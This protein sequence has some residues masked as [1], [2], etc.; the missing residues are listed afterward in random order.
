[1][2][3]WIGE[4]WSD[5]ER[6]HEELSPADFPN[7][8]CSPNS[9]QQA[10]VKVSLEQQFE[11]L[12]VLEKE[13]AACTG[14]GW[15]ALVVEAAG[16]W[17]ESAC[18]RELVDW[19]A[20]LHGLDPTSFASKKALV[21]DLLLRRLP[22]LPIPQMYF[23]SEAWSLFSKEEQD[24]VSEAE[25]NPPEPPPDEAKQDGEDPPDVEDAEAPLS[26]AELAMLES[27]SRRASGQEKRK[28]ADPTGGNPGVL[29]STR[30]SQFLDAQIRCM[31]QIAK[32]FEPPSKKIKRTPLES[33]MWQAS[34]A[35]RKDRFFE[36]SSLNAS[37][38]E[39]LKLLTVRG[40]SKP[41]K[42]KLDNLVLSAES[43]GDR[44]WSSI[45]NWDLFVSGFPKF[46]E[47]IL[48]VP[49]KC[50]MAADRLSW[51]GK[52]CQFEASADKKINF[53]KNF[54]CEYAAEDDWADL[55]HRDSAMLVRLAANPVMAA[56]PSL[57]NSRG[58][59]GGGNGGNRGGAR[60]GSR[61][62]R[63]GRGGRGNGRGSG[64][65][66]SSGSSRGGKV[67]FSRLRISSGDCA[68]GA[69]CKFS[70]LCASCGAD[71]TAKDCT[72]WDAAKAKLAEKAQ[73]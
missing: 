62:A 53:A 72:N 51:F 40:D 55:F 13:V 35:I 6:L 38:L 36:I 23:Y 71:H 32:K 41:K 45:F 19:T 57:P 48:C 54:H 67:C 59:G 12:S 70:H 21:A 33:L 49:T 61:G 69:T 39:R 66:S 1:M 60:G 25:P 58:G 68:W 22:P 9:F 63:Q 46:V 64:R 31:A 8:F 10:Q 5:A 34:K 18:S 43:Q 16:R 56:A 24:A 42:I 73:K 44:K 47:L 30:V 50:S 14:A 2:R 3:P 27:L 28:Q 15:S 4:E 65:S 11:L 29:D 20:A 17:Y 52:L 26:A 37:N 7:G